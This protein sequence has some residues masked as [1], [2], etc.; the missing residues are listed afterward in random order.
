MKILLAILMLIS[1]NAMAGEAVFGFKSYHYDREAEFNETNPTVG[2]D[3]DNGLGV[4]YMH[5]NSIERKSVLVSYR[6]QVFDSK[7]FSTD[8]RAGIASGYPD[9]AKYNGDYTYHQHL[10]HGNF[11]AVASLDFNAKLS[12][13]V[14]GLI[15]ITPAYVGL[16]FKVKL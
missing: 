6:K 1:F 12:E 5:R 10:G 2:Y 8:I 9:G 3:F 7:Y 16:G 13:N 14:S 4:L 15:S 11:R